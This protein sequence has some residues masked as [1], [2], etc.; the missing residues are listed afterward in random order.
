MSVYDLTAASKL[1]TY[2]IVHTCILSI[3]DNH[4]LH[5]NAIDIGHTSILSVNDTLSTTHI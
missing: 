2:Y 3:S 4:I 1:N 5:L